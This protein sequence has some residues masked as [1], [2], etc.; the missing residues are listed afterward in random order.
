[1][2]RGLVLDFNDLNVFEWGNNKV[3]V[4]I[5]VVGLWEDCEMGMLY[6]LSTFYV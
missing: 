6:F 2:L 5:I 3:V 4:V 1:M